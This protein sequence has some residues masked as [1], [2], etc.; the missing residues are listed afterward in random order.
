MKGELKPVND[1]PFLGEST[2]CQMEYVENFKWKHRIRHGSNK[3][4]D[5]L[6]QEYESHLF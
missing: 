4:R 2:W 1:I 5:R 6:S 3:C